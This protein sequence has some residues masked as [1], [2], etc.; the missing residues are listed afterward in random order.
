MYRRPCAASLKNIPLLSLLLLSVCGLFAQ[1]PDTQKVDAFVKSFHA[2]YTDASDLARQL[3]RSFPAQRDKARALYAWL[4]MNI[5]YD[6]VKYNTPPVTRE[7][8]GRT[9]RE[10]DAKIKAW[11]EKQTRTALQTKKGV[12]GDFSRLMEKMCYAVDLECMVVEG[13]SR[14][15][16]G[17]TAGNH[18]WNAIQFDG[19]WHLVDATWGAGY[20][21]PEGFVVNYT[22]V[23]F[24]T[25]P[26]LFAL[27]HLPDESKWQLLDRPIS[28]TTFGNQPFLD[29]CNAQFPVMACAPASG[30][31]V[32][33]G[34]QTQ[35]R[36]KLGAMPKVLVLRTA[37]NKPIAS[38][39]TTTADG[40]VS[41]RF[42]AAGTS[43]V[44]VLAG[45]TPYVLS[46]LARYAVE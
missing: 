27:N 6:M 2:P 24:D 17:G 39:I 37:Q 22:G 26:A 3:T 19:K 1:Q 11:H 29:I 10:I 16:Q 5:R 25:P 30:K 9:N 38:N 43:Q 31:L 7:F 41:L 32:P 13:L 4:A 44:S 33:A 42:S 12:C 23:Y 35:I 40:W 20:I 18:V 45:E 15:K 34:G 46:V 8:S 28:K 14:S 36:L 21:N